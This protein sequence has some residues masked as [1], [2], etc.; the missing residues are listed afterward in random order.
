MRLGQRKKTDAS[1]A[2]PAQGT[3]P[4]VL[5]QAAGVCE[6]EAD[7]A[8]A[9]TTANFSRAQGRSAGLDGL[10]LQEIPQ[11]D[12]PGVL[13]VFRRLGSCCLSF[14]DRHQ[15]AVQAGACALSIRL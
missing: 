11:L 15:C 10:P 7:S 4:Q 9:T 6:K 8:V 1:L 3:V 13:D 2:K 12:Y 5:G 14:I